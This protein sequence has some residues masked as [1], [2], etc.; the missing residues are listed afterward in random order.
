MFN[1]FRKPAPS[2]GWHLVGLAST[3]PDIALDNGADCQ[4]TSSCKAFNIPK[5]GSPENPPQVDLYETGD[6]KGQVLVFKYNGNIHA[7][8]HVSSP[9]DKGEDKL[10]SFSPAMSSLGLPA[11]TGEYF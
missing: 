11:F 4:V 6:L 9:Q 1:P 5:T 10:T 2:G 8:D 3:F 7:I